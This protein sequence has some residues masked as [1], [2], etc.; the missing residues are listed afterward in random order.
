MKIKV[1][2][3]CGT[4]GVTSSV[5][6]S[7]ARQVLEDAGYQVVTNTA[8]VIEA[9]SQVSSFKP[10]IILSTSK[11]E[12]PGLNILIGTPFLTGVGADVLAEQIMKIVEER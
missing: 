2:A 9:K 3:L 7:K 4:G 10:D 8:K 6:A 1:L 11:T 5:I 12:V